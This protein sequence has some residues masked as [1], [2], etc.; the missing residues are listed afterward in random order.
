MKDVAR[1]GG[2]PAGDLIA[3]LVNEA[4]VFQRHDA[5]PPQG[6]CHQFH[7]V[8]VL[9]FLQCAEDVMLADVGRGEAGGTDQV[10]DV[11]QQVVHARVD[12]VHIQR[13]RNAGG[14]S[15]TSRLDGGGR[16]VTVEVQRPSAR[17]HL[18]A[19]LFRANGQARVAMPQ[20]GA[21]P[22]AL[23]NH[24]VGHLVGTALHHHGIAD[25]EAFTHQALALEL[26]HRVRSQPAHILGPQPQPLAHHHCRRH[27][28]ARLPTGGDKL[29]LAIEARINRRLDG[30]V[31]GVQAQPDY[32]KG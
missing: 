24:D 11:R 28:P 23:V 5:I 1:A 22:G 7:R 31:G 16:V 13:H 27:L 20:N 21:L 3:R 25:V 15:P 12:V 2:I 32:V 6:G 4:A 14:T 29:H 10:V 9:D 17:E 26:P 8:P 19:Q 18:R 30:Y